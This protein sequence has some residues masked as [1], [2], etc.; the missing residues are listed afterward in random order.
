[1]SRRLRRTSIRLDHWLTTRL[2]HPRADRLLG[3][4]WLKAGLTPCGSYIRTGRSGHSGIT[5]LNGGRRIKACDSITFCSRR[6]CQTG[7]WTA[8]LTDGL[9]GRKTRATTR[10]HGS[11]SIS[12]LHLQIRAEVPASVFGL[13][14]P[15]AYRA[16]V[17]RQSVHS[18]RFAFAINK[19]NCVSVPLIGQSLQVP[20][21]P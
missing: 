11:C 14:L 2:S 3:V 6:I 5:N 7:S 15:A 16:A 4:C 8:V 17:S 21:C 1:M 13:T 20:N 10:Q 19:G 18:R 9:V 12:R